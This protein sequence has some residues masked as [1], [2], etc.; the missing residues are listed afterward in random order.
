L[1]A[2]DLELVAQHE[3]LDVLDV[4]AA[5]ATDKRTKQCPESEVEKGESHVPDPPTPRAKENRHQYWHPSG[6][7]R[8]APVKGVKGVKTMFTQ[9]AAL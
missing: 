9:A 4:K 3:Q 2:E 6:E 5:A 8:G 1:A 7:L